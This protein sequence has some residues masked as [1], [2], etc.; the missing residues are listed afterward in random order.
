MATAERSDLAGF[1][2]TLTAEQ[3]QA[4]SLCVGWRVRDVVAHLIS[5]DGVG[6]FVLA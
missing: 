1:L 3:W 6:P 5:F 2:G 4:P